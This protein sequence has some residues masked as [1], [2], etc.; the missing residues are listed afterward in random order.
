MYTYLNTVFKYTPKTLI[1]FT[2]AKIHF[3][4]GRSKDI[5]CLYMQHMTETDF[6]FYV[7]KNILKMIK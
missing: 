3:E 2:P 1:F 5:K 4:S 7:P 6:D